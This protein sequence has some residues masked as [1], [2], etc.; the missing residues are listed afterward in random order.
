MLV[1]PSFASKRHLRLTPAPLH[2]KQQGGEPQIAPAN[3]FLQAEPTITFQGA[4]V[5]DIYS[6][7]RCT[8]ANEVHCKYA[9]MHT[10][11]SFLC[12]TAK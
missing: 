8:L 5:R 12:P 9:I 2:R 1:A 4:T 11:L 7:I 6:I 3:P 10:G